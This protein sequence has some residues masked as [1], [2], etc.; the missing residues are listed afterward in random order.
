M[1]RRQQWLECRKARL[2]RTFRVATKVKVGGQQNNHL[3]FTYS[4][5]AKYLSICQ[6]PLESDGGGSDQLPLVAKKCGC[7]QISRNPLQLG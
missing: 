6:K 5:P 2:V 4:K 3:Y 7:I 1:N